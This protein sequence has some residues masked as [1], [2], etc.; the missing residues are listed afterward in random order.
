MEG[1]KVT[2]GENIL[3]ILI[4]FPNTNFILFNSFTSFSGFSKRFFRNLRGLGSCWTHRKWILYSFENLCLLIYPFRIPKVNLQQICLSPNLLLQKIFG[5]TIGKMEFCNVLLIELR[6]PKLNFKSKFI[7]TIE[8]HSRAIESCKLLK[9]Q[10]SKNNDVK[11]NKFSHSFRECPL[12]IW[13]VSCKS[14]ISYE[15]S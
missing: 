5:R 11:K 1:D 2:S 15:F 9:F 6:P 8:F 4:N 12:K 7:Y 14:K 10:Y 13:G 3:S